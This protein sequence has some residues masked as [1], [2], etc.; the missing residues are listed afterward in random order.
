VLLTCLD[1]YPLTNLNYVNRDNNHRYFSLDG[2]LTI[3]TERSSWLSTLL[4]S[5]DSPLVRY[6]LT[7]C[8]VYVLQWNDR[9]SGV[10]YYHAFSHY[11]SLPSVS[12]SLEGFCIFSVF[13][14]IPSYPIPSLH[15][16]LIVA[17]VPILVLILIDC[18]VYTSVSCSSN[19]FSYIYLGSL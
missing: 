14:P 10:I 11:F 4:A 16:R 8:G 17:L 5:V 15:I 13:Y 19:Q 3:L 7:S 1:Q 2:I 12:E 6:Y 9:F 18:V